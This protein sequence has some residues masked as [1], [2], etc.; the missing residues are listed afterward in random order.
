MLSSVLIDTE[1]RSRSRSLMYVRSNPAA[2]AS[3][4]WLSTDRV[5]TSFCEVDTQ[6]IH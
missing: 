3:V 2:A 6:A 5:R 1:H 4:F